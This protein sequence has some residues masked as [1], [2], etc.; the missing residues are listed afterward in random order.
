MTNNF[1]CKTCLVKA[2]CSKYC[3]QLVTE[4]R[5]IDMYV[6]SQKLCPDCGSEIN[7]GSY[8]VRTAKMCFNCSKV[9]R[10][11]AFVKINVTKTKIIPKHRKLKA[12]FS[13]VPLSSGP[14]SI[15]SGP[16]IIVDL[17]KKVFEAMNNP[18][19]KQPDESESMENTH[20]ILYDRVNRDEANYI[21][22]QFTQSIIP[23]IMKKEKRPN[24][25]IKNPSW[26]DNYE[27]IGDFSVDF[28]DHD[29]LIIIK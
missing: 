4:P 16:T 8:L 17:T 15:S 26:I 5:V 22:N 25:K 9:F 21:M 28:L 18:S 27:A 12:S 19:P 23:S 29:P 3:N 20:T 13:S 11:D 10:Q 6:V 14:M 24:H 1:P 7:E 2:C